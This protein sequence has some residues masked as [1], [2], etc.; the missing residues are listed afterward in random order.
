MLGR[1]HEISVATDDIRASV[2]FY[3][4]LGFTQAETGD[5][6]AHPYGVLT[7]GRAFIGL[8]Q[9][10]MTSPALAFVRPE[11]AAHV[12]T[13]ERLGIRI[14]SATLTEDA[15]HHIAFED[16]AG[17]RITIQE[18][19]TYSPP[20]RR[21]AEASLCGYFAGFSVPCRDF[22]AGQ[23]FWELL[24]FVASEQVDSPYAR[25]ELTSDHLNLVLHDPRAFA[26]PMLL[27]GDD[28]A[29]ADL[30]S[31]RARDLS[32][33]RELPRGVD[34]TT[35]ALL[36]SPDGLALLLAQTGNS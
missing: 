29:P 14:E 11:V 20:L 26:R 15:F 35:H 10:S 5:T 24:G 16:P 17:L 2:E 23:R 19:R 18:A 30:E 7:D 36:E 1:F 6:W 33:S 31:M 27:F 32:F 25:I 21:V 34:P 9:Q 13:L 8:H 12:A 28:D 22:A 4:R 3:E